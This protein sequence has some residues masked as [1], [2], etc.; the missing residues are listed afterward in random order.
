MERRPLRAPHSRAAQ[1]GVGEV[2][3]FKV[4]VGFGVPTLGRGGGNIEAVLNMLLK[5]TVY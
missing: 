4:N 1:V 5:V 3:F 2:G